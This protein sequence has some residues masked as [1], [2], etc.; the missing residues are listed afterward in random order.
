MCVALLSTLR[1]QGVAFARVLHLRGAGGFV[2]CE[3]FWATGKMGR[4]C[5]I[6]NLKGAATGS[7]SLDWL[8]ERFGR[9]EHAGLL[10]GEL[11]DSFHS[12][13]HPGV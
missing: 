1:R 9:R 6:G 12:L 4:D 5:I 3:D 13:L 8:W 2:R 11:Y 10:F 7:S